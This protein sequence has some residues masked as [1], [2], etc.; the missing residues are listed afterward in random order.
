[1]KDE[2]DDIQEYKRPWVGLTEKEI[3]AIGYKYGAGGL[4]L[5]DE[6]LAML[7]EKNT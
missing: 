3:D 4:D 7:K 1:M 2:D 6:L 5:M